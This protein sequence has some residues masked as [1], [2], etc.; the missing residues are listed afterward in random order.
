MS[1]FCHEIRTINYGQA[2]SA[3]RNVIVHDYLGVDL[4][5]TW[6]IVKNDLPVLKSQIQVILK[7]YV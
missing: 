7:Q 6:E 2:L 1:I 5:L 3:F 4:P